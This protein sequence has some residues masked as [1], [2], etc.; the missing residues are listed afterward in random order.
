MDQ[1][2]LRHAG[3]LGVRH[4]RHG[5]H[6][7]PDHYRAPSPAARVL[8][9]SPSAQRASAAV[10]AAGTDRARHASTHPGNS[11][12]SGHPP[13]AVVRWGQGGRLPRPH[14]PSAS[15]RSAPPPRRCAPPERIPSAS[16]R[17]APPPR[18]CA[19]PG[20]SCAVRASGR[21]AVPSRERA[22]RGSGSRSSV[23]KLICAWD[24]TPPRDKVAGRWLASAASETEGPS[25]VGRRP[26]LVRANR[27]WR[28]R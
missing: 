14:D 22:R 13:G 16:L 7:W 8:R 26:S 17:S 10:A 1:R 28:V 9:R 15:L 4:L 3:T 19:P 27:N 5:D 24:E 11:T 25:G 18:R 20:R 6:R 12:A 21:R 2:L 23:S